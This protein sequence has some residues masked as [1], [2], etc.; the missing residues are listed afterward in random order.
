MRNLQLTL[1]VL[2]CLVGVMQAHSIEPNLKWGKPTDAELDMTTYT[3][4]PDADAVVLCSQTELR[5][6]ISSGSFRLYQF[7]KQRIKILKEEGKEKA[8]GAISYLYNGH[9]MGHY[10]TTDYETLRCL[11]TTA[12][13]AYD[14]R[15]VPRRK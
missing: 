6:E 2:V 8:N 13:K 12:K 9:R 3:P 4:D 14:Q 1:L 5:Y 11:K 7:V 15:I 10:P